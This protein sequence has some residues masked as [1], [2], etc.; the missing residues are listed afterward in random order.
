MAEQMI[1]DELQDCEAFAALVAHGGG[2]CLKL[3]CRG[4]LP[5]DAF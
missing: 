4:R 5:K 2:K 3:A 1:E